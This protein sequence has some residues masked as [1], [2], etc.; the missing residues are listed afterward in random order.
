MSPE[1]IFGLIGVIVAVVGGF[2]AIPYAA[3][4]LVVAGGAAAVFTTRDSTAIKATAIVLAVAAAHTLDVIP[5]VGTQLSAI[6][7]GIA[8]C[9]A[10]AS[11]VLIARE[12]WADFKP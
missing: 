6:L 7:G 10:A 11:I 1:K 3:L 4:V 8:Q 2:V 5:A 12:L 9:A